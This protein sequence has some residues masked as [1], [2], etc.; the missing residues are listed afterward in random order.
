LAY[1]KDLGAQLS[2]GL[3]GEELRHPATLPWGTLGALPIPYPASE[4]MGKS[5]KYQFLSQILEFSVISMKNKDS[6]I[7]WQ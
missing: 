1:K 7:F 6:C 2:P 4:A 3:I 5:L